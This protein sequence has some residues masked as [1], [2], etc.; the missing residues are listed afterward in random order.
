MPWINI[1]HISLETWGCFFCIIFIICMVFSHE[2]ESKK[3]TILIALL[4][5]A[6][7]LLFMDAL[8][9]TFRGYPGNVGYWMVR[10]SNF[11]VFEASD[12][13]FI[14]FML[15]C[16]ARFLNIQKK[17]KHRCGSGWDI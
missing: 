10:I 1:F 2:F 14:F 6:A 8:A 4:G 9:W 7:F 13:M 16:G 15:M 17:R 5:V 12:L 3:R 11:C